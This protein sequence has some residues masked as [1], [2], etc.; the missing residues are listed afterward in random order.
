VSAAAVVSVGGIV[1][2]MRCNRRGAKQ[3]TQFVQNTCAEVSTRPSMP[4]TSPITTSAYASGPADADFAP[5]IDARRLVIRLF[6]QGQAAKSLFAPNSWYESPD[7]TTSTQKK[8]WQHWKLRP[9][10]QIE[11]ICDGKTSCGC[12]WKQLDGRRGVSYFRFDRDNKVSFIR[13]VPE[14]AGW[15]KFRSNNMSSL[16]PVFNI[17]GGIKN[18]YNVF[19][20]ILVVEEKNKDALQPKNGL[21][22]PRTR[23]AMDVV[24]YL[25]EEA[26]FAENGAD[27]Y[28]AECNESAVF[29]D[30]TYVD[31]LWPK[32]R[33]A[34]R[35][36]QQETQDNKPEGFAFVLDE[37]SDGVNACTA[38]WHVEV[39]GQITP[40]G[41]TYFEL[42]DAGKVSYVRTSYD[43][44]F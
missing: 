20:D 26:Q 44:S 3:K 30:M 34:I 18:F 1:A 22:Q 9:T 29:E 38:V 28:A 33:E 40:R 36:F 11:R 41:V 16:S 21:A 43:L 37:L 10:R 35:Q 5:A 4:L 32:T 12:T 2:A 31:E 14:P 24:R 15:T 39:L 17:M 19:D 6:E 23:R 7:K 13:E 25:F 27:R 8:V 42:D